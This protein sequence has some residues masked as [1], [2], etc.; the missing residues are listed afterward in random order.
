MIGKKLSRTEKKKISFDD[1]V[2]TYQKE[3]QSSINFIGQEHS[4][5]VEL[6]A[7]LIKE[8]A[9]HFFERPGDI[10][11]LDIG[12]GIGLMDHY[13]SRKFNN[14]FGV[15]V[16]R[17]II[18]KA[19]EY[20]PGVC[21]KLY[22]GT[23]MPFEDGSMDV[24]FAINVMHHVPPDRWQI[25]TNEMF[26]ITKRG[27]FALV[28]EHNPRNPLT[29]LAVSKCEFDQDA[30]LLHKKEVEKLFFSSGLEK[31][32]SSFII[33]FPFHNRFFRIIENWL[34]KIPFGAQFYVKGT[35]P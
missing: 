5:F 16:E 23:N 20:N 10:R 7:E 21:Y 12:C 3:I 17:G 28:F 25:F 19:K 32:S 13:L 18:E 35:K 29:R 33:F 2:E 22:D 34:S 9:D 15:D 8:L 14:L 1:Y 30:K 27:G 6:K 26:R 24:V 31:I 4:F 11:I